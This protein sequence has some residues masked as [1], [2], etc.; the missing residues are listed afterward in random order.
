MSVSSQT[1]SVVNR[2]PR[3]IMP[4]MGVLP[5]RLPRM[6]GPEFVSD[7]AW[8]SIAPVLRPGSVTQAAFSALT[9]MLMAAVFFSGALMSVCGTVS[10]F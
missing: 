10:L 4:L 5:M 9:L 7:A 2:P 6:S 3:T 8:M 1:L